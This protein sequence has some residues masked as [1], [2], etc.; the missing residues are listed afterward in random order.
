MDAADERQLHLSVLALGE[1]RIGARLLPASKKRTQL[2]RWLEVELPAR[3]Q[4]R[5]LPIDSK[6]AD[7][8]GSMAA[9]SRIRGIALAVIDGLMAATAIQ[10]GLSLVTRNVKHFVPWAFPSSIPGTSD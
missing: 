4:S 8:W 2:E 9:Q 6:V 10:H 3:F 5:I 1:I 7:L